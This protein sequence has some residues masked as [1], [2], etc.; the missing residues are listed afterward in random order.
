MG[1]EGNNGA[2]TADVVPGGDGR[3]PTE[4]KIF[5]PSLFRG[6]LNMS[7]KIWHYEDNSEGTSM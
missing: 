1:L 2:E 5:C 3:R 4:G 6:F 7:K